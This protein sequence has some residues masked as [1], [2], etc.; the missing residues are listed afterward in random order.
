MH[1]TRS[2]IIFYSQ[3]WKTTKRYYQHILNLSIHFSNHWFTE[4]K[5][6]DGSFLSIA[7]AEH[8]TI[9]A[10][11]K[12]ET[13]LSLEVDNIESSHAYFRAQKA[14]PSDIIQHQPNAL[15]FYLFDPENR[16]IEIWQHL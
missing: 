13:T 16:R 2:N 1:Y 7:N 3:R 14:N 5:L 11:R 6:C 8:A 4:F 9:K 12:K 15:V 10:A